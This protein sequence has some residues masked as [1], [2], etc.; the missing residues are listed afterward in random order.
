M[1]VLAYDTSGPIITVGTAENGRG[2]TRRDVRAERGRGNLLEEI[3]DDVLNDSHWSRREVEGLGLVIGPGS[4]TAIRI[5]WATAA[6][7][8]QAMRIPVT[9]WSVP[10]VHQRK[11]GDQT[12]HAACC[13]HYRGDTFLLYNL[14]HLDAH[15]ASIRLNGDAHLTNAP[16]ILTGP[17][18]IGN[19]ANW[20]AC[21]GAKTQ[22]VPDA[23]AVIGA[24]QLAIWAEADLMQG[25]ALSMSSSPLDYGLPPDFKKLTSA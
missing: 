17:G 20:A 18:I 6:G 1:K 24:D 23:D 2:I 7:W 8:A 25:R 21:F 4:L 13:T 12:G 16:T 9:G 11:F 14:S 10:E 19:R 3:F 15:P 5:G 22:I